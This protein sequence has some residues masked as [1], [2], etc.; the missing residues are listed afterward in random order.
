MKN[1]EAA[2]NKEILQL[3]EQSLTGYPRKVIYKRK[4]EVCVCGKLN[5]SPLSA[6]KMKQHV[7]GGEKKEQTFTLL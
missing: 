7:S 3:T 5:C 4:K 2:N 6:M 1:N